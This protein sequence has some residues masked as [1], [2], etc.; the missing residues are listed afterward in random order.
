MEKDDFLEDDFL[1]ELIQ[2]SPL[3]SPSD[4]FLSKVME[5]VNPEVVP[6]KKP[7][8]LYLMPLLGYAALA[9]FLLLFILSSDFYFFDFLSGSTFLSENILPLFNSI[10]EP[11]KS[12]LSDSKSL[13]I[14]VMI[15]ISAGLFFAL[16]QLL[17]RNKVANG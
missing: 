13:T 1:R 10:V 3:E 16:D 9:A 14:P 11:F 17:S 2:K 12:L 4:D 8:Y 5:K 6:V 7:F 15:V